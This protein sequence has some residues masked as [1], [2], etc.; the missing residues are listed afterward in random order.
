[1]TLAV[2]NRHKT[3]LPS[4]LYLRPN[5]S[6]VDGNELQLSNCPDMP[7]WIAV[8]A[9][10]AMVLETE[11]EVISAGKLLFDKREVLMNLYVFCFVASL[12]STNKVNPILTRITPPR[13]DISSSYKPLL[14]RPT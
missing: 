12:Q 1:M 4:S 6:S 5:C 9:V 7:S 2:K 11:M 10:K 13:V 3:N 8:L 14:Q